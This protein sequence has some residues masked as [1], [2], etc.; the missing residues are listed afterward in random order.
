MHARCSSDHLIWTF[1]HIL[2]FYYL[3]HYIEPCGKLQL[4]LY[5]PHWFITSVHSF[6]MRLGQNGCPQ[7][8]VWCQFYTLW[9]RAFKLLLIKDSLNVKNI[10]CLW[11]FKLSQR[12]IW[13]QPGTSY[14]CWYMVWFKTF[15]G[16]HFF[17]N[18]LPI[19][20]QSYHFNNLSRPKSFLSQKKKNN[21]SIHMC[22]NAI[23]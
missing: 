12:F 10:T 11:P 18:I 16:V 19:W 6:L 14:A 4:W 21:G 23:L 7:N 3:F 1:L 8:N 22:G 5:F 13:S 20:N 15:L 17:Y 9:C 2:M